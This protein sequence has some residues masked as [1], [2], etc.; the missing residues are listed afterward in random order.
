MKVDL[1]PTRTPILPNI[2]HALIPLLR[3][4]LPNL[5]A[6]DTLVVAVVPLAD[7]IRDLDPGGAVGEVVAVGWGVAV[8]GPGELVRG[9]AEV[10]ELKGSLGS[11]SGGDVAGGLLVWSWGWWVVSCRGE[12]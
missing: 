5:R 12:R 11:G 10:E 1:L 2:P 3:P 7:V 9:D 6:R 8:G 4:P